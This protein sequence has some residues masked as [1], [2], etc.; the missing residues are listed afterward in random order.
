[1]TLVIHVGCISANLQVCRK[2][3]KWETYKNCNSDVKLAG[4]FF[5]AKL[6][7][8]ITFPWRRFDGWKA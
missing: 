5:E 1:M 3:V 6:I 8:C 2:Q 4:Q 7:I